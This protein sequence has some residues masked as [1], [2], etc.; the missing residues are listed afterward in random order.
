MRGYRSAR[1]TG[2]IFKA[3]MTLLVFAVIGV[4]VWRVFLSTKLPKEVRYLQENEILSQAYQET[5]GNLTFRR[6]EQSSVTRGANNSGYFSVVDC[7]FIPEANQVQIVFRYNN[8]TIRHLADD[9]GLES[10][11]DKS[12][13]LFEVTLLRTTDLTPDDTSDNGDPSTFGKDRIKPTASVR[14]ETTLYTYYRYVFDN[15][16]IEDTTDGIYADV[17]YVGDIDYEK[18]AYG[19]LCLYAKGDEWLDYSLSSGDKKALHE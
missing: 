17:Y 8:S 1:I 11:P 10:I 14:A 12:E 4:V 18:N 9:Y 3:L 2:A 16:T 13:E 19:T 7:V 15:V 5:D 6:Q